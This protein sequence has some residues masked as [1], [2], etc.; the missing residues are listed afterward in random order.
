[1]TN[2][3]MSD[4]PE[5]WFTFGP[6]SEAEKDVRKLLER[7]ASGV[8]LTFSYGT[9]DIHLKRAELVTS[10]ANSVGS[11][12]TVVGD[13]EGEKPRVA[14]TLET[15][16]LSVE[17]GTTVQLR[18]KNMD[19]DVDHQQIPIDSERLVRAIHPED[20][21]LIGDGSSI[22]KA[23]SVN[24]SIVDC[25]V[26][27][28]GEINPNR[29]VTIQGAEF[30]P[31]SFRQKD[32]SDL[33]FIASNEVFDAVAVSFVSDASDVEIARD[34]IEECDYSPAIIS[35]IETKQGIE[36]AAE[37]AAASD[38]VMIA[39]GDL[40]LL[41]PWEELGINTRTLVSRIQI[42]DAPWIMATQVV[43]GVENFAFPTRA[44][45]CDLTNWYSEG[46]DGVLLS[47]ET[48]FGSHPTRAVSTTRKILDYCEE[49]IG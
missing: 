13:L 31:E 12:C 46:M 28:G 24:G 6:A 19:T 16:R 39:R 22:L 30:E 17:E 15:N 26:H 14:D 41:L 18:P 44:E 21:I 29:G 23:Q 32:R 11:S 25:T 2:D 10:I 48:A 20:L 1:M 3:V 38:A 5:V 8:R 35:K 47:Y 42:T 4:V 7:G 33:K 37:I 45:I 34:I 40:A 9:P 49:T 43:E 36:N 27:A